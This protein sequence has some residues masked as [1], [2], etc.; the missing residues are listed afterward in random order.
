[1]ADD[2]YLWNR[3]GEPDPEIAA[4]ER[5]LGPLA[6]DRPLAGLPARAPAAAPRGI[7]AG[8]RAVLAGLRARPAFALATAVAVMIAVAIVVRRP[9][10]AASGWGVDALAGRPEVAGR[11]LEG[12]GELPVGGWVVTG[13]G[14]RARLQL[15]STGLIE[16]E[17]LS[18]VR[19]VAS[20]DAQ[21]RLALQRGRLTAVIWAPPGRFVV[22]TPS[23]VAVDLGCAYTLDV[24][25]RGRGTVEVTSGWVGFAHRGRESFIPAGARCETRP[26]DG[27]GTPHAADADSALIA[28]LRELDFERPQPGRRAATLDTV[29]AHVRP[30]DAFTVWHLLSRTDGA[31]RAR[32]YDALSALAPPPAGVDRAAVMRGDPEALDRWW[33]SLGLG[34][35]RLWRTWMQE[36]SR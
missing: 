7:A 33:D 18:R 17:P 36:W 8:W 4:L 5:S 11:P 19:L 35:T 22:E 25:A 3:E 12:R 1:M 14:A 6:H 31:A 15:E 21:H 9:A 24:D 13:A 26:G 10:P 2:R 27:P 32:A 34:E 23:A 28:G 30:A 29:L 20:A 16:V